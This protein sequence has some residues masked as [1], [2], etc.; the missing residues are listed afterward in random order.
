M[1]KDQNTILKE[2]NKKQTYNFENYVTTFQFACS[3]FLNK[4]YYPTQT[5]ARIPLRDSIIQTYLDKQRKA[6]LTPKTIIKALDL[7]AK[8]LLNA[9]PHE[10][11]PF[12][13]GIIH[14]RAKKKA[15][16]NQALC[17]LHE[18]SDHNTYG[19]NTHFETIVQYYVIKTDIVELR[20]DALIVEKQLNKSNAFLPTY[21]SNR[22]IQWY[23]CLK[24][25]I[26]EIKFKNEWFAIYYKMFVHLRTHSM[27]KFVTMMN[28][29][30]PDAKTPCTYD[31]ISDY[32]YLTSLTPDKWQ[33]TPIS[34]RTKARK[35][36]VERIFSF[37][38]T[39]LSSINITA[40][41]HYLF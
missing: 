38:S 25:I 21:P 13:K 14:A 2:F 29:W 27:H 16:G 19:I 41:K 28:T 33:N 18:F 23:E 8:R 36:G 3:N 22:I 17:R 40:D 26:I 5:N 34:V 4:Y 30:F 11:Q 39:H 1:Q 10:L 7:E 35:R 20:H 24:P 9:L 12:V 15:K 31:A 6:S 37:Y 32:N